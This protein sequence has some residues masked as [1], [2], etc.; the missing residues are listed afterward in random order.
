[1]DGFN[2]PFYTNNLPAAQSE[3]KRKRKNKGSTA[4]CSNILIPYIN[5]M[6]TRSKMKK[7]NRPKIRTVNEKSTREGQT[8]FS[9][10][11]EIPLLPL[12]GASDRFYYNTR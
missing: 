4:Y 10:N 11:A 2:D 6:K 12:T 1:M 8:F 5:G 3:L 9:V 7:N